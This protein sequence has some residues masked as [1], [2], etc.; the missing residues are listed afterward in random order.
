MMGIINNGIQKQEIR[1]DK[2]A[3]LMLC[4]Y[5]LAEGIFMV[6][7]T[8]LLSRYGQTLEQLIDHSIA[9]VSFC[10]LYVPE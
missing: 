9:L 3:P 8:G 7:D 5:S 10:M 1:A 6:D 4:L 2:A